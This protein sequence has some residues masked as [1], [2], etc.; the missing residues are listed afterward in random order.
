MTHASSVWRAGAV[1]LSGLLLAVAIVSEARA[2]WPEGHLAF[3]AAVVTTVSW[4]V[5]GAIATHARPRMVIGTLLILS[6]L[7]LAVDGALTS[8]AEVIAPRDESSAGW[9]GWLGSWLFWPQLA[10]LSTIY[11]L[12]PSDT[13]PSR[14]WRWAVILAI[15]GSTVGMVGSALSQGPLAES[16][17]LHSVVNPVGIPGAQHLIPVAALLLN[18]SIILGLRLLRVRPVDASLRGAMRLVFWLGLINLAVGILFIAPPGPWV[19]SLGVPVTI[20]LTAA[21]C[22]ALLRGPLWNVRATMGRAIV[23]AALTAST[24]VVFVVVL[25]LAE[26]LPVP[27]TGQLIG[28]PVAAVI[29]CACFAPAQQWLRR[30]VQRIL[31][32]DRSEP[33]RT[34]SRFG[35][36]LEFAGEPREALQRLVEL[37][38]AAFRVPWV[39]V[40]I[41][42]AGPHAVAW[43]GDEADTCVTRAL[44]YQGQEWGQLVVGVRRGEKE[45]APADDHLL[46]DLSR[47]AGA[48]A[49]ALAV[50]GTLRR[51]SAE[52]ALVRDEERHR[53]QRDLHDGVA[54]RITALRL[55]VDVAVDLMVANQDR[56]RSILARVS[57]D[58]AS[59]LTDVRRIVDD[60]GPT[61]TL[62]L[63]VVRALEALCERFTSETLV[64]SAD[65]RAEVDAVHQTVGVAAYWIAAEALHNM[66]RHSDAAQG[67]LSAQISGSDLLLRVADDGRGM[68]AATNSGVGMASMRARAASH[69]GS[70]VVGATHQGGTEIVVRLPARSADA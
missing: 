68:A 70:L 48:A 40:F 1:A 3:L 11:L 45:F 8:V 60:L 17:P 69:G 47:Q 65:V 35:E 61:D 26:L 56:A 27:S 58:L 54:S 38:A 62:D 28:V 64:V 14:R 5:T 32:G 41:P 67:E 24:I 19:Y 23:G 55:N 13:L 4:V 59:T 49:Y 6:G 51:H 44:R 33:Y 52:L 15:F 34:V 53:L 36:V 20:T 18:G 2:G 31:F 66:S 42:S 30:R 63:G 46:D 43:V 12:F 16:G 37:A 7:S 50:E 21:I 39:A 57:T 29:V 9:I 25:L 22:A 10:A